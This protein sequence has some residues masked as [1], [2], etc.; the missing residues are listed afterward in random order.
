MTLDKFNKF[1]AVP[2]IVLS[3]LVCAQLYQNQN[4]RTEILG[5][6]ETLQVKTERSLFSIQNELETKFNALRQQQDETQFS[7]SRSIRLLEQR[8]EA[9]EKKPVVIMN[10]FQQG[11][12]ASGNQNNTYR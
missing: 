8:V 11:P 9:L 1:M 2:Q 10:G 4:T 12:H 3:L 5:K 7:N 6:I